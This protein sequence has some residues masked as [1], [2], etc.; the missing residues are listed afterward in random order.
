MQTKFKYRKIFFFSAISLIVCPIIFSDL[1]HASPAETLSVRKARELIQNVAGANFDKDQVEIKGINSGVAGGGVIVD[2]RI[3]TAFRI[4]KEDGDWRISD[5]RL[6]N[7]RWES[8][9]LVDEAVRREKLRRTTVILKQFA[10]GLAAYHRD[11]G[12]FVETD[13]IAKLLDYLSPRYVSTPYR[14][15]LWGEQ[16]EYRGSATAYRL[17]SS[18][19]DQKTGTGDDLVVENGVIR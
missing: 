3:D 11:R 17:R 14:F 6:G 2:A 1:L 10:D 18:G 19:P 8:L 9:E 15:D 7:Q 13:K 12:R 5:I 4:T 16:F